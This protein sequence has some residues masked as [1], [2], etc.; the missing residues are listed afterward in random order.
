MTRSV[1]LLFLRKELRDLRGNKQVWPAYFLL[2]LIAVFLPALLLVLLPTIADP[3]K[4]ATDPG[5]KMLFDTIARDPSLAG[6]TPAERM[7]RLLLRDVQM[8][9]LLMP[10][11]LSASAAALALVR[12]KEQRTL[13]PILATP[14]RDSDL[15]LAKLCAAAGPAMAFTWA[16]AIL[17]VVVGLLG[18]WWRVGVPIGPTPGNVVA[19]LFLA[20]AMAVVAGLVGLRVSARFTDVPSATQY[21]GLVVVPIS[22]IVVAAVGRPAMAFPLVGAIGTAV[23][24]LVAL[25][26]FARNVRRF[27]REEILTRWK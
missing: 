16:A 8:F 13:E 6:A 17:G 27:R 22:L 19:V 4:A 3:V 14:L 1:L 11:I 5:L 26:M 7:A 12:E 23:A 25:W 20:P 10:V 18:S 2:P 9:Y 24:V 21:T 15:L